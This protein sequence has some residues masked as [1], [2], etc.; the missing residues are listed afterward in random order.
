MESLNAMAMNQR[1]L[2]VLHTDT[3]TAANAFTFC[4]NAQGLFQHHS[5]GLLLDTHTDS[6]EWFACWLARLHFPFTV[7]EPEGL[8]EALRVKAAVLIEACEQASAQKT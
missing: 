8:K 2:V 6:F 1:V 4:E 5:D 3:E 7:L